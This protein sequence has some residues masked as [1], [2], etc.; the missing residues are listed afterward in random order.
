MP[1]YQIELSE[2]AKEDLQQYTAAER[3]TIVVALRV[4][5]TDQPDVETANR[6]R[7]RENP[8]AAWELRIG[9]FRAFYEVDQDEV[10]ATVVAIGHK[11]HNVLKIRGKVVQL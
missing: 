1:A 10:R 6:K 4:Q 7:L 9:R 11:E 8:V 2:S 3:K 5:L